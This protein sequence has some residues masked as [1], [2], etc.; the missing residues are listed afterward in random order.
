MLRKKQHVNELVSPVSRS[1]NACKSFSE[2]HF[3]DN[4]S[5]FKVIYYSL[6]IS[7]SNNFLHLTNQALFF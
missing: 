6:Y 4:L 7:F 1:Y 5:A 2:E 3:V